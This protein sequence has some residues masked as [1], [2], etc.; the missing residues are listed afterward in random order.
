MTACTGCGRAFKPGL[1]KNGRAYKCCAQCRDEARIRRAA[2]C[3]L[4]PEG[5]ARYQRSIRR[6]YRRE[7]LAAY[8]GKC[9]CCSEEHFEFLVIDH[10]NGG[11]RKE[12]AENS[13]WGTSFARWLARQG[14]PPGYRVLCHNCNSAIGYYGACPHD[15]VKVSVAVAVQ[16]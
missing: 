16:T 13:V 5:N 6:E 1:M 10:P 7:A 9:A 8:G 4:D 14:F 3:A 11:G 15:Q 12:R 2:K